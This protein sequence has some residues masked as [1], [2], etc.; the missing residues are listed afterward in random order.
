[1]A[2]SM[3]TPEPTIAF[4]QFEDFAFLSCNGGASRY[5]KKDIDVLEK[6]VLIGTIPKGQVDLDITLTGV[7]GDV[8]VQLVTSDGD[9][10]VGFES[11]CI[12]T[13]GPSTGTCNGMEISYS[14][15]IGSTESIKISGP[16]SIDLNLYLYVYEFNQGESSVDADVKYSWESTDTPCCRREEL[17]SSSFDFDLVE[18]NGQLLGV[19]DVGIESLRIEIEA[20]GDLDLY[21]VDAGDPEKTAIAKAF[22]GVLGGFMASSAEYK[23]RTYAYSGWSGAGF[24]QMG[25]EWFEVEGT[26]NIPLE[27]G[28]SAYTDGSGTVT[29]YYM[30]A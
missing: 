14:G 12:K 11:D 4:E 1:M 17:C 8:D 5:T 22:T 19:F 16:T 27:F 20:D 26:T 23:G 6:Q 21:V 10:I 18:G 30:A 29:Y 9:F 7:R 2:T 13:F 15:Y 24:G 3:P 25:N 28:V